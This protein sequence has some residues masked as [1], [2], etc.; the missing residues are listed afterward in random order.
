MGAGPVVALLAMFLTGCAAEMLVQPAP[1]AA[2]PEFRL[3]ARIVYGGNR[4]YLPRNLTDGGSGARLTVRYAYDVVHG[5]ERTNLFGVMFNP[6]AMLG[7]P[8]IGKDTVAV[9]GRLEVLR[10]EEVAKT[11]DATAALTNRPSLF[12]EGETYTEMRRRGLLAV[13]DSI[14]S[15]VARDRE[16]LGR[17]LGSD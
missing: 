12:Y 8:V 14:E 15:Q 2:A 9:S 5:G 7:L 10:G 3:P 1:D 16:S 17:L 6:A 4:E 11:Y 13:R